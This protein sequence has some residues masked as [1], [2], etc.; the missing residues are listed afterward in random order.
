VDIARETTSSFS[1][2]TNFVPIPGASIEVLVQPGRTDLIMARYSAESA[3][4]GP[5]PE[6]EGYCSIQIVARNNATGVITELEPA[7]GPNMAFDSTDGGTESIASWESHSM[8]RSL[9]LGE[10]SYTI[11][12]QQRVTNSDMTFRLDDWS[13][14]V[15]HPS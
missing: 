12:A 9:N 13:F 7:S 2:S 4:T 11:T 3:C 5:D 14:T 1:H 8:D 10:G 15:E 6:G